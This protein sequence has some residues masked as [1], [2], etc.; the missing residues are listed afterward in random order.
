MPNDII[1][2]RNTGAQLSP[3]ETSFLNK[4]VLDVAV[5]AKD[6]VVDFVTPT[7]SVDEPVEEVTEAPAFNIIAQRENSKSYDPNGIGF[8]SNVAHEIENGLGSNLNGLITDYANAQPSSAELDAQLEDKALQ[9]TEKYGWDTTIMDELMGN[10]QSVEELERKGERIFTQQ[11]YM[12]SLET[13]GMAQQVA[14][15]FAG[16][17]LD[18]INLIP[19][20]VVIKAGAA[21]AKVFPKIANS[22]TR[23]TLGKTGTYAAMGAVEEAARNYPRL[24]N[25]PTY[26]YEM[27]RIDVAMGAAFGGGLAAI[28]PGGKMLFTKASTISRKA[29]DKYKTSLEA[30]MTMNTLTDALRVTKN[31]KAKA[32][33]EAAIKANTSPE[34]LAKAKNAGKVERA[35]AQVNESKINIKFR[36]TISKVREQAEEGTLDAQAMMKEFSEELKS[37]SPTMAKVAEAIKTQIQR[38]ADK[39][40]DSPQSMGAAKRKETLG[41]KIDDLAADHEQVK[42]MMDDVDRV[43]DLAE[44]VAK[45]AKDTTVE[46]QL[47]A[48]RSVM[49]RGVVEKAKIMGVQPK[50]IK[51]TEQEVADA[52]GSKFKRYQKVVNELDNE[53]NKSLKAAGLEERNILSPTVGAA[54]KASGTTANSL[55]KDLL[56]DKNLGHTVEV[57]LDAAFDEV[58]DRLYTKQ[59]RPGYSV[60]DDLG[61]ALA[62]TNRKTGKI[63]LRSGLTKDEILQ[64][65]RGALDNPVSKQK[66]VVA[67][68]TPGLLDRLEKMSETEL[69]DFIVRHEFAH[70]KQDLGAYQSDTKQT[71][72]ESL[73]LA[74]TSNKYLSDS[75]VKL[76]ADAN[77]QALRAMDN[78][79][80]LYDELHAAYNKVRADIQWARLAAQ[81]R[82]AAQVAMEPEW[83]LM[84][85][86]F[87]ESMNG[88]LDIL[89]DIYNG[90]LNRGLRNQFG[91]FTRSYAGELAASKTPLAQWAALNIFELPGGTGGK[92]A[93]N[94]TAAISME[95]FES[96][97]THPVNVAWDKAVRAEA[98]AQGLNYWDAAVMRHSSAAADRNSNALG[99]QVQLE[100]NARQMGNQ[101]D[102]PA[103][104]KAFADELT[105]SYDKL[106][107]TQFENGVEGINGMNKINHYMRQ[108]WSEK[109]VMDAINGDLGLGGLEQLITKSLRNRNPDARLQDI[110]KR[111][112]QTVERMQDNVTRRDGLPKE[113]IVTDGDY[114]N[115]RTLHM[116]MSTSITRNGKEYSLLDYMS[117]DVVTDLNKYAKKTASTSAISKAS[118]G[119]LNSS[120]AINSFIHAVGAESQALG[121]HVD[122]GD[123][124]NAF[125]LMQGEPIMSFDARARKIRDAV[126]L[127]GMNGLGESQL[128][129]L[130][131]AMNRGTAALF[132]ARQVASRVRGKYN[133]RWRGL[134]LTPEQ[135][136]NTALLEEMQSVSTLYD[137]MHNFKRQN[138]H[139]D[140][141]YSGESTSA[142]MNA[143]NKAVDVGTG[144]K[145]RPVLQHVQTKHTGY[146]SIRTMQEEIAMAG[147]MHDVG[148]KLS[149]KASNTSDGRLAD[150]GV[151]MDLLAR[152]V[153]DG[154]IKLDANGNISTM[155]LETWSEMEKHSLGVALRRHSAQQVQVGFAGETSA[156]MSNP[157]V[158]FMMQFRSYPNI[159]A[160]KQQMRNA[161]FHDKEAAMGIA[162]NGASSMAAR[163]IRYQSLAMAMP[164]H[165]REAYLNRKY[166]N[167]LHDTAMYM[168]G[169]GT[170]VNTFD[171]ANNPM[172]A[173]PPVFSWAN[174]YRKA[175]QGLGDGVSHRDIT[176][177]ANAL[178]LGTIGQSNLING[179]LKTMMTPDENTEDFTP[180]SH[181][182]I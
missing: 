75:A 116:D 80:A 52:I 21:T 156:L 5:E 130:G 61:G 110:Q 105:K 104:V 26:S 30:R 1:A 101:S 127:S 103:H 154:S 111:A 151:P 71:I 27:Y 172:E 129:E 141:M 122:V 144:G 176:N 96:A 35:Q 98:K 113:N 3:N 45:A 114:I 148:R 20:G 67:G 69:K 65:V 175:V 100:M 66:Q 76:E 90:T 109:N 83:G 17:V 135:A 60:A 126:A 169:V 131:L 91:A 39:L 97:A 79:T 81:D 55:K 9:L 54:L 6:A 181:R 15:G 51:L 84:S 23:T 108:S 119:R 120:D 41:T 178:P 8:L 149:G 2:G 73:G 37:T 115:S 13:T 177:W 165:K 136:S 162:L 139:F 18:P 138:V 33:L 94:E 47:A 49:K 74:D 72:A 168:G 46:G 82:N 150:I 163:V 102:A 34:D 24:M 77:M 36:D 40:D 143:I 145:L 70:T 182:G 180:R 125:K 25:D 22:L 132:A 157:W 38:Q 87:V 146:G 7:P 128:A 85:R 171:I 121:T 155:G 167:L 58:I 32:D 56:K 63:T 152:K 137:Q 59:F 31:P 106:Y 43:M 42:A 123:M 50:S 133:A 117:N 95:M 142:T 124:V 12:A 78:E 64:H 134:E 92:L 4:D 170:M 160:E 112:K 10:V 68:M 179:Q 86:E 173:T 161:M 174:N 44:G 118:G 48:M 158:A 29:A 147:L 57:N 11:A 164:E 28:M 53:L 14:A 107:K 93:R 153:D 88:D 166:D 159:A 99:R 89:D 62:R 19:G 16:F 140:D